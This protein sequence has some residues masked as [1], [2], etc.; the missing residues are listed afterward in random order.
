MITEQR[1]RFGVR[2]RIQLWVLAGL[3]MLPG[4]GF[5]EPSPSA[6]DHFSAGVKLAERGDVDAAA[7]EFEAAYRISPNF[8]VLYNLGEAYLALGKR[9]EAVKALRSY[10]EIG[11]EKIPRERR[12][13]VEALI[14]ETVKALGAVNFTIEP[15]SSELFVD[16]HRQDPAEG[17]L[18]APGE[19]LVSLKAT[20]FRSFVGQV[21]IAA[22]RS[23]RLDLKLEPDAPVV[24]QESTG[25]V[26]VV[27]AVPAARISLDGK[28]QSF[29][30]DEPLAVVAG[31]HE[32]TCTRDG[33]ATE[34][35]RIE[36]QANRVTRVVCDLHPVAALSGVK[37]GFVSLLV[38]P[39]DAE[40]RIDGRIAGSLARL[41]IG[42]H[43]LSVQRT[44]YHGR[45][46]VIVVRSGVSQALTIR[47]SPTAQTAERQR[48]ETQRAHTWSYLLGG[49]GA[50]LACSGVALYVENSSRY[51]AWK[52]DSDSFSSSLARGQWS[53]SSN[54]RA[55]DLQSRASSIQQRD[56]IA[57]GTA[58][59]GGTLVA[60]VVIRWLT[61]ESR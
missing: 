26:V 58:A 47:L 39:A 32:I 42:P 8:A 56:D 41:P 17:A 9:P 43:E 29:V 45:N 19:H 28:E 6:R 23:Q 11:A 38:Q 27:S 21:S 52:R 57:L 12:Q 44:G 53:P 4:A 61:E 13:E 51:D 34:M 50:A 3:T 20:G 48:R 1:S 5:A 33:Y 54:Q 24:T 36:V 15:S 18:L 46:E 31:S 49:A 59:V 37:V 35:R 25:Q 22:G 16:G 10:L 55:S 60:Y 40:V 30:H 14:A 7:S 2:R